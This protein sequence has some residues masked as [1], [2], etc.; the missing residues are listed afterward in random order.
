[1]AWKKN[2]LVV[3]NVT[4]S[5][6]ELLAALSR[7][8]E[9]TT[10]QF[11]LLVPATPF[12]GGR[13][14]AQSALDMALSRLREAGLAVAGQLGDPDPCLAVSEIWNPREYDEIVVST[15]PLGSSKWLHAGLPERIGRLTGAPVTHV[16]SQP[17]PPARP[18]TSATSAPAT[19]GHPGPLGPLLAPYAVLDHTE[20]HG[21]RHRK[22]LG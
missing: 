12:A 14:A 2:V 19:A 3:A 8:A 4:A 6:E 17:S 5:S 16:V 20:E 22:R 9:G 15:L 11:T 1:M 18:T 13:E 10:S 7:L 21:R